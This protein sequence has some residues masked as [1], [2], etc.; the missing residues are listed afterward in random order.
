MECLFCSWLEKKNQILWEN[1][2]IVVFVANLAFTKGHLLVCSVKHFESI[3]DVPENIR[4][5]IFEKCLEMGKKLQ[6]KL[7]V[8]GYTLGLNEKLY[9]VQP[10]KKTHVKHIHM[11]VIPRKHDEKISFEERIHLTD[12]E[13]EELIRVLKS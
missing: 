11:H 2:N 13:V 5:T 10:E 7:G 4:K 8:K 12:Q 1:E 3:E 9:I 6:E